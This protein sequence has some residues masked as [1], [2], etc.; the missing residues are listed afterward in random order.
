MNYQHED[1]Y[2]W[3]V[4]LNNDKDS[5]VC[6]GDKGDIC[7]YLGIK[8]NSLWKYFNRTNRKYKP[9]YLIYKYLTSD[10]DKED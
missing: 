3:V 9:K 1:K 8:A 5:I 7:N 2:F 4:Y 6:C 10:L